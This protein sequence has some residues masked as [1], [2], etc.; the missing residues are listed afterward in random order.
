[1]MKDIYTKFEANLFI[2][3]REVKKVIW[4]QDKLIFGFYHIFKMNAFIDF[5]VMES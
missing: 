2:C 4:Q 1:M 5:A 3:L